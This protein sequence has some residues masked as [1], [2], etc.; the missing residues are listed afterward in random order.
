ML[1]GACLIPGDTLTLEKGVVLV[2]KYYRTTRRQEG[3]I[4]MLRCSPRLRCPPLRA[5]PTK[6]PGRE[7]SP[8][9]R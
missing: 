5:P 6:A 3:W 2:G 1:K 7:P 9:P 4:M 8:L